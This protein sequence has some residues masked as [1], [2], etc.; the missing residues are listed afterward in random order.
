MTNNY[1]KKGWRE[2]VCFTISFKIQFALRKKKQDTPPTE[3]FRDWILLFFRYVCCRKSWNNFYSTYFYIEIIFFEISFFMKKGK[4]KR[5][6]NSINFLFCVSL[7]LHTLI[8]I[9]IIIVPIL[10]VERW[11]KNMKVK[12]QNRKIFNLFLRIDKL[13]V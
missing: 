11:D 12:N 3:S 9:V 1:D 4:E 7:C 13:S 8:F 2:S 10:N 6:K 5:K